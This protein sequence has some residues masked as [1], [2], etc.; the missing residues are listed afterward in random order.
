MTY[1]PD[2]DGFAVANAAPP[3]PFGVDDA[4]ALFGEQA[5]CEEASGVCTPKAPAQAWIDKVAASSAGGV[6]EGLVLLSLDRYV[7]GVQPP[8]IQLP[9]DSEVSNR[10][11]RLFATQFLPD[12][13][14]TAA[15]SRGQTLAGV[16]DT[17]R[18]GLERGS[19]PYTLGIYHGGTGHTLL[20]YAV[21]SIAPSRVALYVYDPNWPATDR[22][23]EFDLDNGSWRYSFDTADPTS[24]AAPWFGTGAELDLVPLDVR[25]APFDEPFAGAGTGDGRTLLTVTTT[26]QH[27]SVRNGSE[28]VTVDSAVPGKGSVVSVT[29]GGFGSTTIVITASGDVSVESDGLL[30]VMSEGERGA[31]RGRNENGGRFDLTSEGSREIRTGGDDAELRAYALDGV[32]SAETNSGGSLGIVGDRQV[33]Y[34]G[35][36]GD[37]SLVSL[38]GGERHDYRIDLEGNAQEQSVAAAPAAVREAARQ[39]LLT[40]SDGEVSVDT[41]VAGS[42]GP[43]GVTSS[44]STV[45]TNGTTTTTTSTTAPPPNTSSR[46][47]VIV[48]FGTTAGVVTVKVIPKNGFTGSF[49]VAVNGP[50]WSSLDGPAGNYFRTFQN[51][52]VN[53]YYVITVTFSDNLTLTRNFTVP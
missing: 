38:P 19:S 35:A 3:E 44:S 40:A 27:W 42:T 20:P 8:T 30:D 13:I 18:T 16:V 49:T 9:L 26:G 15:T 28:T 48:N 33:R 24:D 37:S 41:S 6:C 5:V 17:I 46:V 45:P 53:G 29:R 31:L 21:R 1:R 11:V 10:V 25:E 52:V 39:P 50:Q 23:I 22:F 43:G 14:Q 47:D 34:T 7:A 2:P 36:N 51:L 12:V 32:V 4:I